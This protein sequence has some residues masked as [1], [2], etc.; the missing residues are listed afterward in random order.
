MNIY[1]SIQNN[2][3]ESV[4]QDYTDEELY[5]II[6][7]YINEKLEEN[8]IY[9]LDIIGIKLVGSRTKGTARE[10][11]DLDVL[12]EYGNDEYREDD[13]FNILNDEYERLYIGNIPVDINPINKNRSGYT[14]QSWI[15]KNYNYDK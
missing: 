12:I 10:D 11:S 4:V 13:I 6:E 1:E 15:D 14:I 3:N 2:L 7:D 9:D 8:D 5:T